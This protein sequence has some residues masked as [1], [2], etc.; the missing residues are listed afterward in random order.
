M[1]SH[2]RR[3]THTRKSKR[4]G[5][6]VEVIRWQ[7]QLPVGDGSVL[8]RTFE[9]KGEAETFLSERLDERRNG[10]VVKPSDKLVST[11][12]K[13][14]LDTTAPSRRENT[15][16]SYRTYVDL[17]LIPK[18][19]NE[20][21]RL[22]DLTPAR[23]QRAWTELLGQGLSPRTV[24]YAHSILHSALDQAVAW[25]MLS[26]NPAAAVKLPKLRATRTMRPL[27][28]AETKRFLEAAKGHRL[29]PFF[30]LALVSGM[31]PSE[32]FG[33]RWDNVDLDAGVIQVRATLVRDREGWRLRE[34]KTKRGKRVIPL[35]PETVDTLLTWKATQ[36]KERLKRGSGW[37]D[38]GLVFTTRTGEPLEIRNVANRALRSVCKAADLTETIPPPPGKEHRKPRIKAAITL[39]DLRHTAATLMLAAGVHPKVASERLGHASI[40]ITLDTYSHVLPSMQEDAAEKIGAILY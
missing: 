14:W 5:K 24:R 11:Y 22:C 12:L 16:E 6:P 8:R 2:I 7:V 19:G 15:Q 23:I 36:G 39:Y 38:H 17:Y 4:T 30:E 31:R 29:G 28:Q 20:E 33:L 34:P 13:E 3:R 32:L 35:P 9:T 40:S 27:D 10:G 21:H 18:L 26:A 25:R 37:T 1:P